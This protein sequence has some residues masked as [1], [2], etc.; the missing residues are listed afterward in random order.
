M[1]PRI[2]WVRSG[3]QQSWASTALI[4]APFNSG[5]SWLTK[6]EAVRRDRI[7]FYWSGSSPVQLFRILWLEPRNEL[8]TSPRSLHHLAWKKPKNH[9]TSHFYD[10]LFVFQIFLTFSLLGSDSLLSK[11]SHVPAPLLILFHKIL[12][13]QMHHPCLVCK[14]FST[15][16]Y[17][18]V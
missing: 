18:H 14:S 3:F 10:L 16:D 5:H 4:K 17:G 6:A 15:K 1:W 9:W 11:G 13:F 12:G 8:R 2:Y 7:W